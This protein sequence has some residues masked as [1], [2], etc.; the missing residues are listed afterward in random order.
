MSLLYDVISSATPVYDAVILSA[1]RVYHAVISVAG[2]VYDIVIF[3]VPAGPSPDDW[4]LED[5]T[6]DGSL[7][8]IDPKT[9]KLFTVPSDSG[10]YPRP[11]GECQHLIII[12]ILQTP[13]N[14]YFAASCSSITAIPKAAVS[15]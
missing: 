6:H 1:A 2:P 11:V 3:I 5:L 15:A 9:N 8:L 4:V 14:N 12:L 13:L 7:Y 10:S